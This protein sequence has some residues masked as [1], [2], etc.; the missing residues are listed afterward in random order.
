MEKTI[1][2]VVEEFNAQV[3]LFYSP[4]EKNFIKN[5]HKQLNSKN[6]FANIETKS[7]R[8]L[9]ALISNCDMFGK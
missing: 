9:A 1:N 7:I 6:I 8:E 4:D 2:K 3:I 5:L